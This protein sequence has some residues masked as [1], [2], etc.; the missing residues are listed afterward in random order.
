M[1]MP[2]LVRGD[3]LLDGADV[4][5]VVVSCVS[6]DVRRIGGVLNCTHGTQDVFAHS[7]DGYVVATFACPTVSN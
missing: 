6:Q 2:I 1:V 3:N 4:G 7:D 5:H